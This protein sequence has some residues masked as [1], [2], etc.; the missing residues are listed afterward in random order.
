MERTGDQQVL[1]H[2]GNYLVRRQKLLTGEV[3]PWHRDPFHRVTVV[4]SGIYSTLSSA[5]GE[6]PNPARSRWAKWIGRSRAIP[7]TG[8]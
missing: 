4:L 6:K 2:H 8:R 1:H 7:S 3:T 5:M